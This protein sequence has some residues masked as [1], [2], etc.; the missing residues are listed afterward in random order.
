MADVV[1]ELG[2][3]PVYIGVVTKNAGDIRSCIEGIVPVYIGVVT[4][5]W[6]GLG[7]QVLLV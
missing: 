1:T 2:I 4:K 5:P 3:V 7:Y 6:E